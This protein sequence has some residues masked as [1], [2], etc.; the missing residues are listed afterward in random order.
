MRKVMIIVDLATLIDKTNITLYFYPL[1]DVQ[2]PIY[3]TMSPF[4]QH[5][6]Q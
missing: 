5:L 4:S 1:L 2:T 3:S 6:D